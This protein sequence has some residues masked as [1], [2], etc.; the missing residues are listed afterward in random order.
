ME[1]SDNEIIYSDVK[2]P[3]LLFEEGTILGTDGGHYNNDKITKVTPFINAV[4]INWNGAILSDKTINT[5]SD[6]LNVIK[7]TKNSIENIS[8]S[9]GE[10]GDPGLSAYE[11]YKRKNSESSLTEEEWLNSL[12]GE[13]GTTPEIKV[14]TVNVSTVSSDQEADVS[15][16]QIENSGNVTLNFDLK[17]PKGE[18]GED[19]KIVIDGNTYIGEENII[20]SI[21]VDGTQL[22]IDEHKNVNIDLSN[23]ASKSEIEGKISSDQILKINYDDNPNDPHL[24]INTKGYISNVPFYPNV[25][26]NW[27]QQDPTKPDFILNKPIEFKYTNNFVKDVEISANGTEYYT[28]DSMSRVVYKEGETV[29]GQTKWVEATSDDAINLAGQQRFVRNRVSGNHS[30]ALGWANT[31]TGD[32][33]TSEG[34]LVTINGNYSHGSGLNT[35]ISGSY[36][37]GGGIDDGN[38]FTA[39]Y[40]D[41]NYLIDSNYSFAHGRN[42]QTTNMGEVAFGQYNHSTTISGG[43]VVPEIG[44]DTPAIDTLGNEWEIIDFNRIDNQLWN[45]NSEDDYCKFIKNIWNKK[46]EVITQYVEQKEDYIDTEVQTAIE[47]FVDGV[48]YDID[49]KYKDIYSYY[50]Q[51]NMN[52]KI[53][54]GVIAQN[55]EGEYKFFIWGPNSLYYPTPITMFSIGNG[56]EYERHNLFEITSDGNV[57]YGNKNIFSLETQVEETIENINS[58][59]NVSQSTILT[60]NKNSALKQWIVEEDNTTGQVGYEELQIEN[61]GS[62]SKQLYIKCNLNNSFNLKLTFEGDIFVNNAIEDNTITWSNSIIGIESS[63]LGIRLDMQVFN[64]SLFL[65]IVKYE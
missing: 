47:K 2:Q 58:I 45:F 37:Y 7:E 6:L 42:L 40:S 33:S 61:N 29:S 55:S 43:L 35:T 25:Q 13:D 50:Y 17:I 3:N 56:N 53:V 5:T 23:Y 41:N 48:I 30:L 54:I 21:S 9:K 4:D 49:T 12:K 62:Y 20:E 36:A 19:G 31:I 60:I 11:I 28:S 63:I 24:L 16:T 8:L 14:G 22:E 38:V 44:G 27:N 65:D 51:S 57:H 1:Y 32:Y 18:K 34:S 52:E 15:I 46:C 39:N 64:G 10:K 59:S 26:A